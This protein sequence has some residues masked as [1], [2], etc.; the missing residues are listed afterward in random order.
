M[1]TKLLYFMTVYLLQKIFT[2]DII[3]SSE[4]QIN[5]FYQSASRECAQYTEPMTKFAEPG[6]GLDGRGSIPGMHKIF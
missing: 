3:M 6:Y 4:F 5:E 1:L 2:L